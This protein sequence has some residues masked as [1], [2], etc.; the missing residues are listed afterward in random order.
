MK[1]T[2]H[3]H[4]R[5]ST[6]LKRKVR[7]RKK[8]K[9]TDE[10]PRLSVFRSLKYT[11]ASLV[12]DQSGTVYGS[13]S[14]KSLASESSKKGVDTAKE[15]GKQIA[16]LAKEKNISSV[17]FDRNGYLFHGRVAAVAEGARE[18]GLEC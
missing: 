9:G 16:A 17:V 3:L 6:R 11:Y 13:I 5:A 14:T 10:K 18:A 1:S 4:P 15:L 7:V 8:I 12:S 2:K